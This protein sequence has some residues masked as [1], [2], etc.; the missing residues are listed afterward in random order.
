M[1]DIGFVLD[2]RLGDDTDVDGLSVFETTGY[3]YS[4]TTVIL[5]PRVHI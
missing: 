5:L 4:L 3:L 2:E 1:F